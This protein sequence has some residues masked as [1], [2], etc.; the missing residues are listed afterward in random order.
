M[1]H[2]AESHRTRLVGFHD[3][4]GRASLQITL[5]NR[6]C[7]V[8]HLPGT[9]ANPL[10]GQVEHNGT[11]IVDVADPGN[12]V[13][14][15]HIPGKSARGNSRGVQVITSRHDGRDYL[16]R[17]NESEDM[18]GF[19]VFDI[20][21]RAKPRPVSSITDTPRGPLTYAHKGWWDE[22]SGLY[23]A[24]AGEGGFRWG[25][26]LVI[27]D[28]SN[29]YRP[30]FVTRHWVTGQEESEPKP[31]GP[32][33]INLHHPIVDMPNKR[34]Y[35]GYPRG[36]YLEVVDISDITKPRSELLFC[37]SPTFNRGPH[38]VLPLPG[39]KCPNFAPGVGDVRDFIVFVNEA[40]NANPD[41][42]EVRTMLYM[43]DVTARS[44]PMTVDTFRVPDAG[45][46]ERGGRF[47]PHQFAETMNGS[48]YSPKDNGNLLHLAYFSA[49]L[50]ILDISDPYD[51]KEVGHYLPATTSNTVTR[52]GGLTAPLPQQVIQ[53][54]DVDLDE[55][56]LVYISDRAGTGMHII[57][58]LKDQP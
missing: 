14:V 3:L 45:Y 15:A 4:Q 7:Y 35:L 52:S 25:G 36:G 37:I 10:T 21:E 24:T 11:S 47:G 26:H 23:F 48:L 46:V 27:W 2:G 41:H 17:N 50:R 40:H 51:M 30:E 22:A 13:L 49:G 42:K 34:V 55:R 28:L 12:P 20:S 39:V 19:E 43:L 18:F 33:G 53:T 58:Y 9:H 29:P 54:N 6:W 8:G 5:R 16:I 44:N 31:D 1:A 57:E 38:T 32:K 56:G